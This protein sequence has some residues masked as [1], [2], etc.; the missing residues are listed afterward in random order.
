M[1]TFE[2]DTRAH[3]YLF[4]D[5]HDLPPATVRELGDILAYAMGSNILHLDLNFW[6][7]RLMSKYYYVYGT[8]LAI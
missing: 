2:I 7:L 6:L 8:N 3:W 1:I 5:A 4:P